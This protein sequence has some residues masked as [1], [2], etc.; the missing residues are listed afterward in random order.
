M[1]KIHAH[2]LKQAGKLLKRLPSHRSTLPVLTH[3]AAIAKF[4]TLS[5][6]TANLDQRLETRIPLAEPISSP[7]S[8][9]IPPDAFRAAM[10]ADK[11]SIVTIAAKG[12]RKSRRIH[13][14]V[15]C[16]GIPIET[17]HPTA[18]LDDFPELSQ[19]EGP[20]TELPARTIEMLALVA[21]CAS[22]D[23]TRIVLNG[24]H[25]TPED[26]GLLI[27]TDG[28]RLA[29]IP[30]SVP[31]TDFILPNTAVHILGHP[32]FKSRP[33]TVTMSENAESRMLCFQSG[34]HQLITRTQAGNYPAWKQVVPRGMVSSLTIAEERRA[35][36]LSWLRSLPTRD[37]TLTLRLKKRGVL[38]LIHGTKEGVAGTIEV[39]V[40]GT[41]KVPIVSV[42]PSYLATAL[43]IAPTLWLSD[44][45]SPVVAR[46]PDGA[47]CVIMP[48][49]VTH[50]AAQAAA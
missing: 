43:A 19:V 16:K 47:F 27:A 36:T 6:V 48:L 28:R 12:S 21:T 10:K 39:P 3:I 13:L 14:H 2:D 20:S 40:I 1:I 15:T 22:K 31:S 44:E 46:R 33:A 5:L 8:L 50:A 25:F 38:Q 37:G 29:G 49:R 26:G 9:L 42:D 7:E 41:G 34:N 35:A 18:N 24:V 4:D 30:A 11:D 45:M 17:Q 23:A 32:D